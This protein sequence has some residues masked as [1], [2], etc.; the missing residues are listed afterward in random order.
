MENSSS[1]SSDTPA[2]PAAVVEPVPSKPARKPRTDA[3]KQ[4]SR[5]RA[6]E[7]KKRAADAQAAAEDTDT[8]HVLVN[9]LKRVRTLEDR[10]AVV[11]EERLTKRFKKE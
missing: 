10:L 1:S 4:A 3:Q 9:L 5:E 7:K 2:Q 11:E 6:L 8:N